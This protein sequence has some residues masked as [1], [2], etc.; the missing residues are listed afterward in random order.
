M[1]ITSAIFAITIPKTNEASKLQF[2]ASGPTQISQQYYNNDEKLLNEFRDRDLTTLP[3]EGNLATKSSNQSYKLSASFTLYSDFV[4][5]NKM[6]KCGGSTMNAILTQ[7]SEWNDFDFMRLQA[8]FSQFDLNEQ[9]SSDL[10][11]IR[12]EV[13]FPI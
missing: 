12:N 13:T 6:P 11:G 1:K 3:N 9:F 5:H 4:F 8:N 2:H 7:L 10:R